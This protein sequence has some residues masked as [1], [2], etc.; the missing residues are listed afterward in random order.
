M[1]VS[2]GLQNE[3]PLVVG[4]LGAAAPL[5]AA[6]GLRCAAHEGGR[7]E[8]ESGARAFLHGAKHVVWPRLREYY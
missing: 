4:I 2:I 5:L 8:P 3:T 7:G 6:E 1:C